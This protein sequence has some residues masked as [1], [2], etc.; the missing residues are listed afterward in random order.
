MKKGLFV[1]VMMIYSAVLFAQPAEEAEEADHDWKFRLTPYLWLTAISGDLTVRGIT[2]DFDASISDILERA[3]PTFEDLNDLLAAGSP[4]QTK[5]RA[6]LKEFV[7]MA[8][9]IRNL[10]DY[11]EQHPEALIRGKR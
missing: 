5:L 3:E 11:L 10:T 9:S 7:D 4:T 2:A 8:R 1:A 6:M